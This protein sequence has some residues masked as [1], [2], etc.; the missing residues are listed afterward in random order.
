MSRDI[1]V[2]PDHVLVARAAQP[3][4]CL[5]IRVGPR[6]FGVDLRWKAILYDNVRIGV[7]A[8]VGT[9]DLAENVIRWDVSGLS[10]TRRSYSVRDRVDGDH[11]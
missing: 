4:N 10:S 6:E 5:V 9:R 7:A 11:Q 8:N 2:L 3:Q 1:V